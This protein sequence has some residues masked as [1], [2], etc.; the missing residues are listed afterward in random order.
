MWFCPRVWP[1]ARRAS[2][3]FGTSFRNNCTGT[4]APTGR[5]R[6]RR[7]RGPS[8]GESLL[9]LASLQSSEKFLLRTHSPYYSTVVGCNPINLPKLGLLIV[10]S[11]SK[12]ETPTLKFA[13]CA[14]RVDLNLLFVNEDFLFS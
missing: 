6:L 8:G 14:S 12:S 7:K 10:S 9:V 13:S 4:R 11:W 3:S 5:V 2:V 1:C